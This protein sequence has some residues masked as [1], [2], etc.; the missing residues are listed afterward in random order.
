MVRALTGKIIFKWPDEKTA[1]VPRKVRRRFHLEPGGKTVVFLFLRD[2]DHFTAD[3]LKQGK[4]RRSNVQFERGLGNRLVSCG[5]QAG[6][7]DYELLCNADLR[8]GPANIVIV[9]LSV[10]PVNSNS[11][12]SEQTVVCYCNHPY[13]FLQIFFLRIIF[14]RIDHLSLV[15]V[16]VDFEPTLRTS[17]SDAVIDGCSG[18]IDQPTDLFPFNRLIFLS[19]NL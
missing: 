3:C 13:Y 8:P 2:S 12:L 16:Q 7:L 10:Q 19:S 1:S 11:W 14:A 15:I 9:D 18:A 17:S 5:S 6:I 4:T